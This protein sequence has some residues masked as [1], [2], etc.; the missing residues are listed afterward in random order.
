[1]NLVIF[2]KEFENVN[3]IE[4]QKKILDKNKNYLINFS[5]KN[6]SVPTWFNYKDLDISNLIFL[7]YK[8]NRKNL[9]KKVTDSLNAN[10]I[11]AEY[12]LSEIN[13]SD[14]VWRTYFEVLALKSLIQKKKIKKIILFSKNK[15][16]H[17]SLALSEHFKN[18]YFQF[19]KY[20]NFYYNFKNILLAYYVYLNNFCQELILSFLLKLFY[21]N[22]IFNNKKILYANFPNH[23]NLKSKHYKLLEKKKNNKYLVS[24]LRNNSNILKDF[25][26]FFLLK[27]SKIKNINV[28]ESYN[29]IQ[30][31][32]FIYLK[33]LISKRQNITYELLNKLH[34]GFFCNEVER[35]FKLIEK[36]KNDTIVNSLKKFNK[37]NKLKILAYPFFEFID[38]RLISKHCSLNK[39]ESFGFQHSNLLPNMHSRLFEASQSIYI[40][41]LKEYL[42]Q[43]IFIESLFAKKQ[44]SELKSININYYGSF[45]FNNVST[46]KQKE[47][48][49]KNI[50]IVMDL[51][52]RTHLEKTFKKIK[53]SDNSLV[54]IRPHPVY[55]SEYEKKQIKNFK[56][57]LSNNLISSIK[58]NKIKYVFLSSSTGAFMD[59]IDTNLNIIIYKVPNHIRDD[60][61]LK[62]YFYSTH[63]LTD[64]IN[65][66]EEK[67]MNISLNKRKLLPKKIEKNIF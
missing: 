20:N 23:W 2:D 32:I 7:E 9:L 52:N 66:N 56:I 34:L 16:N 62:N 43:K 49:K 22:K 54:Y 36:S 24:L 19:Y 4:S 8:K 55:R 47:I 37:L 27:N 59:L 33:N 63:D 42:P 45:R 12:K 31:I 44:L 60:V 35:N 53:S 29:S 21:K 11:F 41:K 6:F 3:L 50:L 30:D 1:M 64:L 48:N 28:L 17:L 65:L 14:N 39:I 15:K 26:R 67:K 46:F 40:S 10:P 58:K 57:D 38:G 61:F 13:Y 18:N 5:D 25:R 51:H